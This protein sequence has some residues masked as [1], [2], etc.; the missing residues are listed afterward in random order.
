MRSPLPSWNQRSA[1]YGNLFNPAFLMV[2][3]GAACNGFE[4]EQT[5]LSDE[6]ELGMPF[7]LLFVA[8]PMALSLEFNEARPTRLTG[9]LVKWAKK[10]PAIVANLSTATYS[11][12]PAVREAIVYGLRAEQL[13][14]GDKGRFRP[15]P[16]HGNLEL[17]VRTGLA[18][19]VNNAA[20]AGR[21]L[22][23]SGGAAAILENF[24]LRP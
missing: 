9:S 4:T 11:L 15:G 23:K 21:W 20:F 12:V 6:R 5:D 7:A 13:V 2:V 1:D 18:G 8:A 24:G 19:H 16:G 3:L 17:D 22:C 10:H 14:V